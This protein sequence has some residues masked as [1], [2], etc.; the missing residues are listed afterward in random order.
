MRADGSQGATPGKPLASGKAA[1]KE[2]LGANEPSSWR[3]AT[4]AEGIANGGT[5]LPEGRA[6]GG[7]PLGIAGKP[8]EGWGPEALTGCK[9]DGML[10]GERT[11]SET[12]AP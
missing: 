12:G 5:P 2:P 4:P 9:F 8:P 3:R 11:Y 6:Q 1:G 7:R 10:E